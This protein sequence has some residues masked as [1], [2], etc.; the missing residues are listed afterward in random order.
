MKWG[1][2]RP[3]SLRR[4]AMTKRRSGSREANYKTARVII[5]E[6]GPMHERSARRSKTVPRRRSHETVARVRKVAT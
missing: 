6:G 1:V 3:R 5:D 4:G 2:S